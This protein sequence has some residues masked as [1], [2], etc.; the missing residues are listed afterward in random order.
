M[1]SQQHP[2]AEKLFTIQNKHYYSTGQG[3][4]SPVISCF[5]HL[6]GSDYQQSLRNQRKSLRRIKKTNSTG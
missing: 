1:K 2:L 3:I 5:Q 6:V 4:D